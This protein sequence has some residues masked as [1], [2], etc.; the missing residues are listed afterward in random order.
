MADA[1]VQDLVTEL[2]GKLNL[3]RYP[4]VWLIPG[5]VSPMLWAL[6]IRPRLLLPAELLQRLDRAQLRTI[7]LHELAHW[8]RRD[9]WVRLL[10]MAVTVLYWWHPAV[11]WARAELHEAEEQCCDGW[12]VGTLEDA[13]RTYALALLETVAFLSKAR[14]PLPVSASGIGH[15]SHLRRRLTMIMSGQKR[16]SLTWAGCVG[17]L[18]F[19]LLLLP[20]IPVRAQQIE[21]KETGRFI[22]VDVNEKNF[23]ILLAGQDQEA[24][25]LL[26][27]ALK[28]LAD[29]KQAAPAKPASP[30]EIKKLREQ[31]HDLTKQAAEQRRALE[32]TE[33]KLNQARAR[34]AQGQDFHIRFVPIRK[35]FDFT[36]PLSGVPSQKAT[37]AKSGTPGTAI[38]L[39]GQ[40]VLELSD[41]KIIAAKTATPGKALSRQKEIMLQLQDGQ[42]LS[43]TTQKP[44]AVPPDE[45]K[46][47]LDRLLREVEELR[48]AIQSNPAPKGK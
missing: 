24:I 41:G 37:P 10:E 43:F 12:V 46:A 31:V 44:A 3:T 18:A 21:K 1:N 13:D 28:L 19:G 2:A 35:S 16:R 23:D 30:E 32:Q 6:S 26:K 40:V 39:P 7:I 17:L 33:G 25:E 45:L 20:L 4:E 48:R 34:L 38:S 9:H 11:W 27:R 22:F 47:R 42:I 15:V 8:R 29:K 14:L 36:V 5:R